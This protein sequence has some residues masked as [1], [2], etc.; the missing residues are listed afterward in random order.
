[1]EGNL[2]SLDVTLIDEQLRRLSETTEPPLNLPAAFLK[3]SGTFRNPGIVV[4][5]EAA[6]DNPTRSNG[7]RKAY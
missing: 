5:G 3:R 6:A 1:L 4:N 2:T 7:K